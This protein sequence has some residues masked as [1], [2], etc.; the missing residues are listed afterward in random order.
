[1]NEHSTDDRNKEIDDLLTTW[2]EDVDVRAREARARILAA[3]TADADPS[4]TQSIVR[5]IF[6]NRY[7][8]YAAMLALS[9]LVAIY[10]MPQLTPTAQAQD[11]VVMLPDGGRLDA[12]D[13][14]GNEIGPCALR[15]TDA[16]FSVSGHIVRVDVRQ[17]YV[18]TYDTAIEAVYTFPLSHRGAVDRMTM[19]I[20]SGEEIRFVE[21][22]IEERGRAREMYESARDAGYVA[23]L[24]EQERPNIFTQSVANIE[25]GAEVTVAIS[26]V[27]T[28]ESVDGTYKIALPTVVG[29]RYIPGY[30]VDGM[31]VLPDLIGRRG[32]VLR[33]P[34]EITLGD[35]TVGGAGTGTDDA[36][37]IEMIKASHPIMRPDWSKNDGQPDVIRTFEVAYP[38]GSR[39]PG[40]LFSDNTGQVGGR[41]F[42]GKT[43]EPGAPFGQDTD[44]VPD[45][46][47]ITPMPVMPGTR[48]GHDISISVEIESGGPAIENISSPLHEISEIAPDSGKGSKGRRSF[49]LARKKEIPNRDFI[50]EWTLEGDGI[51]ESI[52]AHTENPGTAH[53]LDG[54]R[55]GITVVD[56]HV[57]IIL[58]PPPRV[59]DVEV[60]SRELIFVLDTSGS[61][62]GFPIEKA[63]EVMNRAIDSMRP[64]DT[65]NLIT[66]AGDTNILWDQ[67]KPATADNRKVATDFI[68]SR[69]GGGGTEMMAAI[70]AALNQS[71]GG[72]RRIDALALANLPASGASVQLRVPYSDLSTRA[73]RVNDDMSLDIRTSIA[74]PEMPGAA[75]LDVDIDGRW[76]TQDGK[77]ILIVDGLAFV[78]DDVARDNPMRI[79]VFMTDGYVGNDTGIIEAVKKNADTTRVFSFGIGDSINRYLLDGMARAGR[80]AVEYVTLANDADEAVDRLTRRIETP[81]LID[82]TMETEGTPLLDVLPSGNR[83]P[84]LYDES[85]IVILGRYQV[86]GE[87]TIKLRGRTGQGPW[88]RDITV[89]LPENEPEN[90]VVRSLWARAM[91]D[92]LLGQS[93]DHSVPFKNGETLKDE[94]IALA[95]EYSIM[96][97]YTSFIAIE[98]TRVVSDG[99]PML[100]RVP[101]E[102]PSGTDWSGFF[103]D[104]NA[105]P[106]DITLELATI[107]LDESTI[108]K[109]KEE[110]GKRYGVAEADQAVSLGTPVPPPSS[111][112]RPAPSIN[113]AVVG[114][115][116]NMWYAPPPSSRAGGTRGRST[117]S[118]RGGS[119]PSGMRGM[120]EGAG[121]GGTFGSLASPANPM[122][123]AALEDSPVIEMRSIDR[124]QFARLVRILDRPLFR[125]AVRTLLSKED[126]DSLTLA[127]AGRLT[128]E[129]GRIMVSIKVDEVNPEILQALEAT[130]FDL[131]GSNETTDVVV[132]HA[133]P[134]QLVDIGLLDDVLRVVPASMRPEE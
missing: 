103:G 6:M 56:G 62:R 17:V 64:D 63:K 4:I 128:D 19:T 106:I 37:T 54:P 29:P 127:G 89:T 98:K 92:E 81:V 14:Q 104:P 119:R 13:D 105:D 96:T 49:E 75:S 97:P 42:C 76:V 50:L 44:Q 129:S 22:E 118:G 91:A 102:L 116:N 39:E 112:A 34:G 25:P 45:A 72:T 134:E 66:F 51:S 2:H 133:S 100:V 43:P 65:F 28:L 15:N 121:G 74:L 30:P 18:N 87:V 90:D 88:S 120:A 122:P 131:S 58:N 126:R 115:A 125:I 26:Y 38:N 55:E 27:E 11:G 33:G 113:S 5:R 77:R 1:M 32:I 61:M 59:E 99:K 132:G 82:I 111:A 41:W 67:P 73:L 47:K 108:E 86:P 53:L 123:E 69:S 80:G 36:T 21:G 23:S 8:P 101:I 46:S 124:E 60:P 20:R 7:V 35:A 52:L 83:L 48:A 117:R 109:M 3:A 93:S 107:G 16:D 110:T 79:V 94:V 95:K 57:A 12:F 71:P 40:A 70:D 78:K 68:S 85:P 130:G 24:L 84:D 31:E 9:A 10:A 114:G